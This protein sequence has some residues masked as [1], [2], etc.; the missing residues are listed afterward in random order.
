MLS[1]RSVPCN[2]VL[3]HIVYRDV[4]AAI[5]WL[6]HAFGFSEHY[7]YGDPADPSGA[8]MYFGHVYLM[9]RKARPGSSTPRQLGSATQSLT[10]FLEDVDGHYRRTKFAGV[11]IVE[12]PHLTEYGEYQYGAEDLDDHH[13]L[14]ARHAQDVSPED[15]GALI[16][17]G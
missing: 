15:W 7:R 1:N 14:F 11:K 9:V 10:L 12:E 3:P 16:K 6:T 2:T 5:T 4:A 8:Q 13:W 17:K